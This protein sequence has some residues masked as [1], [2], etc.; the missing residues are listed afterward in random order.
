MYGTTDEGHMK[1]AVTVR[2]YVYGKMLEFVLCN[3]IGQ[4]KSNS[5]VA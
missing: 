2:N 4:T 5:I 3:C 1:G